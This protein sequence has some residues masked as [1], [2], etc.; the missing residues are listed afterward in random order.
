MPYAMIKSLD[1]QL[2]TQ[3]TRAVNMATVQTA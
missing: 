2:R 3:M 1:T